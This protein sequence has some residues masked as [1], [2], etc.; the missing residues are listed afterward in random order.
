MTALTLLG[1]RCYAGVTAKFHVMNYP[2]IQ[3]ASIKE[4]SGAVHPSK[5]LETYSYMPSLAL[6]STVCLTP[7]E[8]GLC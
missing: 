7:V 6:E 8:V 1:M 4:C 3:S 2:L 5:N